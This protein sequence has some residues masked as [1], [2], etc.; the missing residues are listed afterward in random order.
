MKSKFVMSLAVLLC[1]FGCTYE[2]QFEPAYVPSEAPSFL[3][4]GKIALVMRDEQREF[5]YEG[6]PDSE[7]GDF[8]TLIVPVG[9]I[10]RNIAHQV[11]GNCFSEGVEFVET[12]EQAR[13]YT[14]ALTGNMEGFIYRYRR[15][16]DQGFTS[17]EA[18]TWITPEVEVTFNVAAYNSDGDVLLDDTYASG[19]QSGES[20]QVTTR[21][22]ERINEALHA[23]LHALMLEVAADLRPKLV[24]ECEITDL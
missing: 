15:V 17:E 16:I 5:T 4:Y 3:A 23:T 9:E 24:G 7:V 22:S 18:Q 21:A 20:Y 1:T 10:V 2:A 19:V 13:G 11:F 8:T 14:V 6:P 12:L